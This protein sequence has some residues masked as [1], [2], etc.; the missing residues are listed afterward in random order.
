M[1]MHMGNL[2]LN[3]Y[4]ELSQKIN[5]LFMK[6]YDGTDRDNLLSKQSDLIQVLAC[7]PPE[8]LK[9]IVNK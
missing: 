4:A 1:L 9:D 7:C 6:C 5:E 3:A 2:E 8:Q